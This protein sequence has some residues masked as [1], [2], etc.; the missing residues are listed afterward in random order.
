MKGRDFYSLLAVVG[1]AGLVVIMYATE[2]AVAILTAAIPVAIVA[3]IGSTW[4]LW[5]VFRAQ[6]IPR[7]RFFGMVLE[8]FV[9]LIVLGVWVSYLSVARALDRDGTLDIHLPAPSTALS[10]PLTALLVILVFA[11]PVRFA[12]EVFRVRR[13]VPPPPGAG[14]ARDLDRRDPE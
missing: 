6:P 2:T 7:S 9:A 3:A 10:Q 12:I 4:Y 8:L 13:R 14:T 11:T 5:R 1:L